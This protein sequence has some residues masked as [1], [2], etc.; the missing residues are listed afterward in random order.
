VTRFEQ[1]DAVAVDP[2][3]NGH[4]APFAVGIQGIHDGHVAGDRLVFTSVDGHVV[5]FDTATGERRDFDLNSL[6]KPGDDRPLGWCRGVLTDGDARRAWVGF[7]RIRE[8]KLR[9][10]LSW[11]RNGFRERLPTRISLYD[12]ERP[13][14]LREIN[15]ERAGLNAI[16]SIHGSIG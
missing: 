7:S 3:R 15:L 14:L 2:S 11:I 8:T 10:N 12:L 1:R 13:A 6:K 9:Q 16:F 5:R 4:R